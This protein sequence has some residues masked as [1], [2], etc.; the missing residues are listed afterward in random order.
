[1]SNGSHS[2]SRRQFMCRLTLAGTAVVLGLRPAR[3]IA[4]LPPET[5]RLRLEWSGG[6]C[7]APKYV[8]EELLRAEGFSDV[9]YAHQGVREYSPTARVKA[10]G[11]GET[12]F[13]LGFAPPTIAAIDAG[14]SVTIVAGGHI[15]CYELFAGER[16]RTIRDLQGKTIG[17]REMGGSDYLFLAIILSYIGLNPKRDVRWVTHRAADAARLLSDAQIDAYLA[18]PPRSQELRAKKIGH[19]LINSTVDRP[20]RDYF[21]CMLYANRNF[22]RRNPVATKK[23]VR[24]LMKANQVCALD[25]E[26]AAKLAV[27]R[28]ETTSHEY[29]VQMMKEIPYGAWRDYDAETTVR[30]YALRLHEAGLITSSAQKILAQGTD[31]RFLNELKKELKG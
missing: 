19:V 10:V 7:Q 12:D 27:G 1:M 11:A 17:V 22:A 15:G 14:Q 6:S 30:F 3:S 8:A 26:R 31:W 2:R 23:V 16:I 18:L 9:Q 25:P 13:D 28:G 21:C 20:W 4:E 5:T 24:A 29:A